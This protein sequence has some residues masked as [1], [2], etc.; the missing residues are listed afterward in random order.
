MIVNTEGIV[1]RAVPF[2]DHQL[3]TSVYTPEYG[4]KNCIVPGAYSKSGKTGKHIYFQ[5]LCILDI[6]YY[7]RS[8]RTLQK[9]T[10]VHY[11]HIFEQWHT[12][13][14]KS[15]YGFVLAELLSKSIPAELPNEELYRFLKIFLLLFDRAPYSLYQLF[16]FFVFHLTD[17]LGFFP[18]SEVQNPQAPIFFDLYA[19]IIKNVDDAPYSYH[20]YYYDFSVKPSYQECASLTIPRYERLPMLKSLLTYY[21]IHIPDFKELQSLKI[22]EEVFRD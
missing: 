12:H 5:P 2:D 14:I 22:F 19:G 11:R 20:R 9:I 13:P 10:D 7:E 3:I 17:Y 21:S 16:V 4:L 15:S 8:G 1:F 6:V 18:I